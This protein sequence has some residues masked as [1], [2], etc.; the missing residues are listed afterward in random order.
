MAAKSGPSLGMECGKAKIGEGVS[1][2]C[3]S[4]EEKG[5]GDKGIAK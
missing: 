1:I 5:N 3:F 2:F 4:S